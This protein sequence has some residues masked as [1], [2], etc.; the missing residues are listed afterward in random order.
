M[1]GELEEMKHKLAQL[2]KERNATIP[3]MRRKKFTSPWENTQAHGK[4]QAHGK[5]LGRR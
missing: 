2:R 4:S 1:T 3:E 5:N